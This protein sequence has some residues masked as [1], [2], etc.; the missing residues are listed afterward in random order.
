M[1]G[2]VDGL[3]QRINPCGVSVSATCWPHAPEERLARMAMTPSVLAWPKLTVR[4]N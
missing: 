4:G 2:A 1:K 3:S